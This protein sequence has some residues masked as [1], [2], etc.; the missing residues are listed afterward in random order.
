MFKGNNGHTQMVSSKRKIWDWITI[1][2][3][4]FKELYFNMSNHID[5][6]P[7]TLVL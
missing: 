3:T 6:T 4:D 2:Y 1:P 5:L 7:Y